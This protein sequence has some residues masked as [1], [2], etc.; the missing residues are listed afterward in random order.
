MKSQSTELL[1]NAILRQLGAAYPASL[2]AD[3]LALGLQTLGF[4][5]ADALPVE[6]TYLTQRHF[7]EEV[8][9]DLAPATTRYRLSSHGIDYLQ[10]ENLL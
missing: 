7:I 1:R 6:L 10:K 2:P 8:F 4:F 9:K 3:T 5:P